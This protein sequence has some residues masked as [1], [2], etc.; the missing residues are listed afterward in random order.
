MGYVSSLEGNA[1]TLFGF[2]KSA[3][4]KLLYLLGISADTQKIFSGN[5]F[6]LAG[7]FWLFLIFVGLD[8][9]KWMTKASMG[10]A[11]MTSFPILNGSSKSP[12]GL[13]GWVS[14]GS[15]EYMCIQSILHF[16]S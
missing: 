15:P 16:A 9:R 8:F 6:H 10:D 11:G 4:S 5:A 14:A 12:T 1:F 13:T 7:G 2:G 3:E